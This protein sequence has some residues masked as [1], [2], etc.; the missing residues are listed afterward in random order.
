MSSSNFLIMGM[1]ILS[2][3]ALYLAGAWALARIWCKP[4]RLPRTNTPADVDL[5]FEEVEFTSHG[6]PLKGWFIPFASATV[7]PPAIVLAH[8]WCKNAGDLLLLA[9]TLYQNGYA[10]L[11]YDARGHG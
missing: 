9:R 8:G 2:V 7:P 3:A 4:K 6:I 11:L 5:P 10:V 1:M